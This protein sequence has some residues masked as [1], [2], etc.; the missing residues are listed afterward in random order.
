MKKWVLLLFISQIAISQKIY[1][2]QQVDYTINVKLN[3]VKHTLS[4]NESIVYYNNSPDTLK[5]IYF[6]LWPNAYKDNNS[7]LAKQFLKQG[8]RNFYFAKEQDKGYIDSLNFQTD[9][10]TLKIEYDK[11]NEDICKVFLAQALA[12]GQKTTITT[13]FKVKIP[14]AIF[15]RLGHDNQAYYI[16]QWYP[17]PAV[18]DASGWNQM[19]YLDQGEFYSEYG[20]FDVSITLPQNYLLAATGDRY[21]NEAEE[22]FLQQRIIDTEKKIKILDS[23]LF[24]ADMSFPASDTVFK[25]V[26]FKQSN[27]HDFAWFAD[28]R[29]NVLRGEM[30]LPHT[31]TSVSTWAFF[32]DADIDLWRNAIEYISDATYYYSLWNGDY[33]YNNV[34]AIDGNIAAGGGM[35]YPNITIIGETSNAFELDMLITHEVG[36]NWFYSMLGSNERKSAWMD[37]GINSFNELR[38]VKTKYPN[39]TL[40]TLLGHDSTYT[41]MHVNKYKQ[42]HSYYWEYVNAAKQNEDQ[43]CSLPADMFT[44]SNYAAIAYSK[45][46]LLFNYLMNYMGENDF[47]IAMQFYFNQC[48]FKHPKPADLRKTLEYFSEKN[49]SWFFDDLISTT[50]KLDYKVTSVKKEDDGS[51]SVNVK[52]VGSV[53]GPV[54]LY[55]LNQQDLVGMVWYD[56]FEGTKTFLFPPAEITS[57][58]IDYNE[59]MPDINR[60]NNTIKT[61]G[62]LKKREPIKPEFI[63]AIDNPYKTQLFYSPIMGYNLY[64]GYMLGLAY[65]NHV[66]LEKKLETDV[67]PMYAFGNKNITGMANAKL[68]LHPTGIFSTINIGVKAQRFAYEQN[69]FANNYNKLAPYINLDFK[70]KYA[71]SL[72]QHRLTYR[73]VYIQKQI[74]RYEENALNNGY[75]AVQ[76]N[77]NYGVHDILYQFANSSTLYPMLVKVNGQMN[78]DMQKISITLVQKI[79]VNKTKFFE[80]RAF[81]G[82][83]NL[84]NQNTTVPYYFKLSGTKG[85]NDYMYDNLYFGRAEQQGLAAA[86]FTENDGAF[87]VYTFLGQ[88]N[89][90]LTTLN[91]KSPKLF[92]LPLLLYADIGACAPNAALLSNQTFFYDAGIDIVLYRDVFEIFVPLGISKN[93]QDNNTLNGTK[94]GIFQQ[95]RFVLNL[96]S[97]KI[98]PFG[99]IKQAV[100][101]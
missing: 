78:S 33:A 35:E 46:A 75:N 100:S 45:T 89:N 77:I 37:E 7:A 86:Q 65:Y 24:K 66:L 49:L 26:R 61:H 57:F 81:A 1:F 13:P 17:K 21:D 18:Y 38:Y 15:S 85:D 39:A 34:T 97:N 60:K 58:R 8:N 44:E 29:Y 27:V 14:S 42:A 95:I 93:I 19:P 70:K 69:V 32:T 79:F 25:T 71:T 98:N 82:I 6:H 80:I 47:D 84:Q 53:A 31:K 74:T 5:F 54:P 55:G 64:N 52:N 76:Q 51:Y 9:N 68:N 16:T 96:N 28:K 56:G 63:A 40:A 23:S 72:F 73:Y 50:K 30:V 90:W 22:K 62:L 11:N 83:M 41:L 87:K 101:F 12:P 92:K 20:S 43:P 36:H 48:K 91:I 67:A 88:T 2:Q 10:Q 59:V 99:L 94:I 3:D 4:A